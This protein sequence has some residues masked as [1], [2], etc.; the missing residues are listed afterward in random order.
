[1]SRNSP[2]DSIK[3]IW[4]K[5]C[6]ATELTD[7]AVPDD[8]STHSPEGAVLLMSMTLVRPFALARR[9]RLS[10]P[11]ISAELSISAM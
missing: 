3:G 9:G 6:S 8:I 10:A 1:M 4:L 2:A 11:V 7:T 5:H